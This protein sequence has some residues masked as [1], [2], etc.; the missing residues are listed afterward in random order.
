M[1]AGKYTYHWLG[2]NYS[3]YISLKESISGI[4]SFNIFGIPFTGADIC[5]FMKNSEKNLCVRWYNI[6]VFYPFSRNHNFIDSKDQFPWSF[7]PEARDIIKKDIEYRYSLIR[8]M[9]SQLFLISLNEKGSFFKPVLFEFPNEENSYNN[10]ENKIMFGEAFLICAFYEESTNSKLF[11]L[12]KAN[13]NL[14]PNGKNIMN[15]DTTERK[16]ELS[17]E[18]NQLHIFL[19]GG[20]IIPMQNSFDKYIM[21]T[22]VLRGEKL[23]LIINPDNLLKSKGVLF[24]DNDELDTVENKKYFRVDMSFENK[25]MIFKLNKN[26]LEKY[27]YRDNIIEKIEIWRFSEIFGKATKVKA[28]FK[29]SINSEGVLDTVNDKVIFDLNKE[30]ISIF[31]IEEILFE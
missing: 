22:E 26:N 5:G 2:D 29:E 30:A 10:I 18:F 4:F 7:G 21:N 9:Y 6:G 19:R 28:K 31:D 12:P 11:I 24:F 15:Y 17:G 14:Y 1:G 8:Y 3:T 27:N 16:I 23:N 20:Y 13:F 25:K